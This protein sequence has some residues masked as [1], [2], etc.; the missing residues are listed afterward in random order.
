[1][2]GN[3]ISRWGGWLACVAV[4]LSFA[5]CSRNEDAARVQNLQGKVEKIVVNPD[6]T[7]R[8]TVLYFSEKHD[9]EIAGTGEVTAETEILINGAVAKL[10][11]IREG[12]RIRGEVRIEKKNGIKTQTVLKIFI[13]RATPVGSSD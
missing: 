2:N 10:S 5:G 1:M 6:G 12:E 8:I 11:D 9:E 13:D 7:G 3:R 4:S